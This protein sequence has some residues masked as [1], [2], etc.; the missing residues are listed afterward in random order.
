MSDYPMTVRPLS[1]E[2]GGGWLA[3][4]PDLPG[5]LA[6]GD[7]PEGAAHEAADALR[8]YL[9]TAAEMGRKVPPPISSAQSYSGRWVIRAPRTLHRRLAERAR[10]E[11]VSLNQF[12]VALLAEGVARSE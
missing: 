6:D 8:S 11:G 9:A 2:E 12:T 7:T 1:E 5:C 3:E 10:R 4:F